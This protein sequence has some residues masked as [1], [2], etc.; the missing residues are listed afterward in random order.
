MRPVAKHG[1]LIARPLREAYRLRGLEA[2]GLA[3][4]PL[5]RPRG[6]PPV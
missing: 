5:A 6:Q 3:E 2:D 4:I 1:R